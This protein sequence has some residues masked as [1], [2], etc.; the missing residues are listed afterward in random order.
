MR[1]WDIVWSKDAEADLDS[2]YSYIS[3]QLL[4][5]TIAKNQTG[6][7]KTAVQGLTQMPERFPLYRTEP[8]R[9][10]GVRQMVINHYIVLYRPMEENSDVLI[11][12]VLYGKR[13]IDK[14]LATPLHL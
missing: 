14:A 6:R 7:I 1:E 2:I 11:L 10:R 5:P 3:A 12:R 8:W 9:S 13:D 4:E